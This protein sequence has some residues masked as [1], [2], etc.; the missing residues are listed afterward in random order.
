MHPLRGLLKSAQETVAYGAELERG[1][2]SLL[3]ATRLLLVINFGDLVRVGG[4]V[5]SKLV[6]VMAETPPFLVF[7][8]DQ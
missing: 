5:Y 1:S 6:R 2:V 4:S 7:T 8:R 3:W